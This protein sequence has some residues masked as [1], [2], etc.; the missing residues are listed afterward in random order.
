M[1]SC[2]IAPEF[3]FWWEAGG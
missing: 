2:V 1:F 3:R